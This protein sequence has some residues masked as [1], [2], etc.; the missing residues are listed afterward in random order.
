MALGEDLVRSRVL[1]LGE[2][3]EG[4]PRG[5]LGHA[6]SMEADPEK[7]LS[8]HWVLTVKVLRAPFRELRRPGHEGGDRGSFNA[9]ACHPHRPTVALVDLTYDRQPEP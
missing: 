2:A 7:A 1:V 3:R 5:L 6:S 9:G 4:V 8:R